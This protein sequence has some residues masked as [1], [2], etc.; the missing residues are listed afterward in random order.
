MALSLGMQEMPAN[1]ENE[2]RVK[3]LSR[4]YGDQPDESGDA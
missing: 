2:R 3:G 1:A 4:R